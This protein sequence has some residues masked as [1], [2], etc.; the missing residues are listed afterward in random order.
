MSFTE[1]PEGV[2]RLNRSE[3]SVPAGETRF[4][5]KAANG[6]ADIVL[7]DLEDSV[8]SDAKERARKNAIAAPRDIDWHGKTLSLRVNGLDTPWM[9]RDVVEVVEQAGDKL[10]LLMIPKVGAAADVYA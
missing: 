9:Y 2:P 6:A 7:L 1:I 4:F 3:L 8:P 5:E 10:N